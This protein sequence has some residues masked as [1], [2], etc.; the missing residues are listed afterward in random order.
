MKGT[1]ASPSF[2]GRWVIC[3]AVIGFELIYCV[4]EAGRSALAEA[5]APRQPPRIDVFLVSGMF[6]R[7]LLG[8]QTAGHHVVLVS[9]HRRGAEAE[10][11]RGS[12][13]QEGALHLVLTLALRLPYPPP[14][15]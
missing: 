14:G 6:P 1:R 3:G 7:L 13:C 10:G 12:T 15:A 4:S 5:R 9:V 2:V 11:A 8:L